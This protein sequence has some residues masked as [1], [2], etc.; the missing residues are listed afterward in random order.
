MEISIL[1]GLFVWFIYFLIKNIFF[2][3]I[4]WKLLFEP[5]QSYGPA[6]LNHKIEAYNSKKKFNKRKNSIKY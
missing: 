1:S 3:R 5:D 2:K 6:R 4:E